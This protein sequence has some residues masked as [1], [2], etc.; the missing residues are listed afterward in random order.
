[1][2]EIQSDHNEALKVSGIVVNQFQP[3][4]SLPQR[5]VQELVD[6]GLPVLQPYL[7]SSV[8]VKESHERNLPLIHLDARHKLTQDFL[9]LHAAI[10]A[11]G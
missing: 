5:I 11:Q 2:Q 1:V 10:S 7:G 9:A 4:A 3:R 8:K 6:E